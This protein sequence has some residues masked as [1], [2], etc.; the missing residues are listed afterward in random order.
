MKNFGT[1]KHRHVN[2]KRNCKAAFTL[3]EALIV[4]AIIGVVA[5]MTIP[6]FSTKINEKINKHQKEVIE[7]RLLEGLNQVNALDGGFD[8]SFYEDTEGF[9]RVLSKY[10]K[11]NQICGTAELD[12][13]FPYS[14]INYTN[15][16]G[17]ATV[18][19]SDLKTPEDFALSS[20]ECYSPASFISSQG[21]SFVMLLKKDCIKYTG[22]A[23]RQL[24]TDCLQYMYDINGTRIPNKFDKDLYHSEPLAL[25]VRIPDGTLLNP[26]GEY[27]TYLILGEA[28]VINTCNQS[29]DLKWDPRGSTNSGCS[30]NKWA[31]AKKLCAEVGY[32]LPDADTVGK[33]SCRVRGASTYSAWGVTKSCDVSIQDTALLAK[34]TEKVPSWVWTSSPVPN[35][36]TVQVYNLGNAR[37]GNVFLSGFN[38]RMETLCLGK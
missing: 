12:K 13:C 26:I 18:N 36:G 1:E 8:A 7:D 3:A 20:D 29:P 10:Y 24:P 27:K 17:T 23:M 30:G 28:P 31:G 2:M 9:V 14:V 37:V 32:E 6:V 21:T 15:K 11:M 4:I 35:D 33:L 19:T 5:A 22:E 16:S 34:Y 38:N 25:G